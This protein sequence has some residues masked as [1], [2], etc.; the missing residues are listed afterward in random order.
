GVLVR[1]RG[2]AEH[3]EL[4]EHEGDRA[5]GTE[6]AAELAERVAHVG[7]GAHLVVGQAV[8]DHRD[9]ARG[10]A[11]VADLL[12][13]HAFQLTGGLLDRALDDVL[14]HVRGQRLVHRGTQARVVARVA[15][16]GARG[17]RDLADEL[18]EDLAPL[19]V[20]CAL[21]VLDVGP[22]GMACHCCSSYCRSHRDGTGD[23][24]PSP[25]CSWR[26]RPWRRKLTAWSAARRENSIP[27]WL[28]GSTTWSVTPSSRV[29]ATATVPSLGPVKRP[30]ACPKPI[31]LSPAI[32]PTSA[33]PRHGVQPR[34][35]RRALR[36][37]ARSPSGRDASPAAAALPHSG[38]PRQTTRCTGSSGWRCKVRT[39]IT[40]PRLW[41]RMWQ[42]SESLLRRAGRLPRRPSVTAA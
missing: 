42:G 9:P 15:A 21:A 24:R 35:S 23:Y 8:D 28:S 4:V 32:T 13:V 37:S 2:K 29:S 34:R 31:G 20:L 19:R 40:P 3:A 12:V 25:T 22:L 16:T 27:L 36:P 14:G 38:E 41:A 17:N 10:V 5:V 11:F 30:S 1:P 33:A 7:H 18:G 39:A 26:K 6:V